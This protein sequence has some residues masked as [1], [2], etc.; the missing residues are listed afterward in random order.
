MIAID[1]VGGV[2]K[3][4]A[5]IDGEAL[6]K[7]ILEFPTD[8]VRCAALARYVS[9]V[10]ERGAIVKIRLHSRSV[11]RERNL[12]LDRSGQVVL[13]RRSL[14]AVIVGSRRGD[15]IAQ[16]IAAV[17]TFLRQRSGTKQSRIGW[18]LRVGA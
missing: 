12:R 17:C 11:N 13:P 5:K 10:G 15:T 1:G 3:C 7:E 9:A 6:G 14:H 16:L 4:L 18:L 2:D 8:S